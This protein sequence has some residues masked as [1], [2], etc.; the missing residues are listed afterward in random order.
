MFYLGAT[1]QPI[2][3]AKLF[4][5]GAPAVAGSYAVVHPFASAPEKTWPATSFIEIANHLQ[6]TGLE[7]VF[8]TG[9]HDNTAP[10]AGFRIIA[11]DL[12]RVKDVL[13]GATVFVGN[14]SGPA[15]MAA[16]F[17]VPLVVLFGASD[18]IVWAPW[19]VQAQA[20]VSAG[21]IESILPRDVI[22]ALEGVRVAR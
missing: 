18:P 19:R 6:D 9:P 21:P 5:S 1:C 2:P 22:R 17:G 20:L 14:D 3:R 8:L 4:A 7:P 15:H 10:F 11:A 16:A 13:S 12:H